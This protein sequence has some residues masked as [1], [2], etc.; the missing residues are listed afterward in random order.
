M[1]KSL[2]SCTVKPVSLGSVKS[3][4][5]ENP[6]TWEKSVLP[7]VLKILI[8]IQRGVPYKTLHWEAEMDSWVQ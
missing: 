1:V 3:H 5:S 2:P 7:N 8:F 6:R 4:S